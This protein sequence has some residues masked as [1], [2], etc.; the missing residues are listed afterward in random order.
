MS[1]QTLRE[2]LL[3]LARIYE[4]GSRHMVG[5]YSTDTLN[6]L[7]EAAAAL[8]RG[9]T[10]RPLVIDRDADLRREM[11]AYLSTLVITGDNIGD[12]RRSLFVPWNSP[13]NVW[14]RDDTAECEQHDDGNADLCPACGCATKANRPLMPC[15]DRWHLEAE[16][17]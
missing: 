5:M 1:D 6:L 9:E 11:R 10:P 12:V 16:Q 7:R 3:N 14:V 13:W 15:R 8:P 2:R 4:T 17:K